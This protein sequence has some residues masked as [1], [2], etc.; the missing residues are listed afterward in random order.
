MRSAL[1][2]GSLTAI[3]NLYLQWMNSTTNDSGK[4]VNNAFQ[5]HVHFHLQHNST[6]PVLLSC[7]YSFHITFNP[8][9]GKQ[10]SHVNLHSDKLHTWCDNACSSVISSNQMIEILNKKKIRILMESEMRVYT[11][12]CRRL[13][14]WLVCQ[15]QPLICMKLMLS[16]S[17][18]KNCSMI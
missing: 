15:L 4:I 2:N 16:M 18:T 10:H 9:T 17:S 13:S 6:L 14:L 1:Q 8:N 7:Y 11:T 5:N 12:S 3:I